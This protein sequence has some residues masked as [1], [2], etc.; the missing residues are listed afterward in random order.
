MWFNKSNTSTYIIA[1]FLKGHRASCE[2]VPTHSHVFHT[3]LCVNEQLSSNCVEFRN[4][5]EAT[6]IISGTPALTLAKYIVLCQQVCLSIIHSSSRSNQAGDSPPDKHHRV[7]L[8]ISL[9]ST[10]VV[11]SVGS[12]A[13][14]LTPCV[15]T[16]L[17]RLALKGNI[18]AQI[19]KDY[20]TSKN[21]QIVMPLWSN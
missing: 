12:A 2:S 21:G 5:H 16:Q 18:L 19:Q 13:C 15:W 7:T 17:M 4:I 3:L 1:V 6:A 14:P 9:S 8:S 10:V 11:C 20:I